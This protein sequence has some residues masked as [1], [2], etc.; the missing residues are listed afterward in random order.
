MKERFLEVKGEM[1]RKG[2]IKSESPVQMNRLVLLEVPYADFEGEIKN[3][4]ILVLADLE[5][6]VKNIFSRL[7]ELDFRIHSISLINAFEGSDRKSMEANNSSSF[8]CRNIEGT[9]RYSKH[10]YGVAI[11]I[12]PVQNPLILGEGA[13]LPEGGKE[14][15]DRNNMRMGMVTPE[16]IKIFAENKFSVWGGDWESIKDYH[17]FEIPEGMINS[18]LGGTF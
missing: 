9:T 12:N 8:N 15:L 1:F 7:L 6:E 18:L 16:V 5:E 2:I 11:D 10:A 4:E 13:V 14:Y 3:G 17:H